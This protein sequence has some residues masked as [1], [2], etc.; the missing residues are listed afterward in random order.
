[1]EQRVIVFFFFTTVKPDGF[2]V[3]AAFSK[4]GRELDAGIRHYYWII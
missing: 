1:M 4:D 3:N 2:R